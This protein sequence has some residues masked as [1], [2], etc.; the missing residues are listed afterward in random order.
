MVEKIDL[1]DRKILSQLEM[2]CRIPNSRLAKDL[3]ISGDRV[4]Y[5]INRLVEKGIIRHFTVF[6]DPWK[7]GFTMWK[8]YLKFQNLP[9]TKE[10]E[11]IDFLKKRRSV[12]WIVKCVGRYD[13]IFSI[14]AK[15]VQGF[16]DEYLEF[17]SLFSKYELE[18]EITNHIRPEADS[19]GY[20][21]GKQSQ[22]IFVCMDDGCEGKVD[23]IDFSILKSLVENSRTGTSEIA[24]KVGIT[25]RQVA[26]RI[27]RMRED[28]IIL[29]FW[30]ILDVNKIGYDYYKA[31]VRLHNTTKEKLDALI[32]YCRQHPSIV[33][34]GGTV[35]PWEVEIE[36]EVEGYKEFNSLMRK[37]QN[38]FPDHIK[39]FDNVLM[40]EELKGELN[41]IGLLEEEKE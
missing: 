8:V 9:K 11:V 7:F 35:G 32:N 14:V 6:I 23:S 31:I 40:Y 41:W 21:L 3:K 5:R 2:D 22:L 26:Y 18:V 13:L 25:A 27:K 39:S 16:F 4:N 19:R 10:A 24:K 37:L 15:N 28:G 30:A 12:W 29:A 17:Q 1:I 33:N 38:H 20:L 36:C 34:V